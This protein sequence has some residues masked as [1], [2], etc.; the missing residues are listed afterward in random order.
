MVIDRSFFHCFFCGKRFSPDLDAREGGFLHS[1]KVAACVRCMADNRGGFSADH[2]AIR[3]LVQRGLI[4]KPAKGPVSLPDQ[5][6]GSMTQNP[7]QAG[8][9]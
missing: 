4:R 2:P 8:D 3:Q 6:S 9:L 7:R 5:E 1:W